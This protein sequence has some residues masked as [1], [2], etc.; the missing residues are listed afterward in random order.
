[1][2]SA[3][4]IVH[5][6]AD[7]GQ[8]AR[9]LRVPGLEDLDDARQAVR[10]VRAGDAARVECPHRQLRA[11]LADRLGGDDA[12]RVADLGHPAGREERAVAA[13]AEPHSLRHL[14]TERTGI[15]AVV[16]VLAE[17][18]DEPRSASS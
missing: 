13:L 4:S 9:T 17:L 5:L 8:R 16:R 18:L 2:R 6:A 3:S 7:V 11:G 10:D 12:D 1:M 15:V 14:S